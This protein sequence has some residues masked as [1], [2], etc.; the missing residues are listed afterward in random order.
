MFI[1]SARISLTLKL[2]G[3]H[4][5]LIKSLFQNLNLLFLIAVIIFFT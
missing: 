3:A 5:E 2:S 4:E 1:K